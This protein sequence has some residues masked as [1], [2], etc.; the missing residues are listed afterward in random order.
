MD[1]VKMSVPHRVRWRNLSLHAALILAAGCLVVFLVAPLYVMLRQSAFRMD[2]SFAGFDN[3]IAYLSNPRALLSI[4]HSFFVAA[5][6]TLITISL[7]FAYAYC[8]ARTRMRGKSLFRGMAMVP[9]LT[10]SLLFAMSLVQLFGNK[11]LLKPLLF[12][13]SI[14]G[15]IGII[16][17]MVFAHIPH[18]F[19]IL[20]TALSIADARLYEAANCLGASRRRIF[21]TVTLPGIKYG[22]LSAC[23]V[24]FTLCITEFGIPQVIGGQYDVLATDIYKQVIGQQNFQ[25]GSVVSVVLLVPAVIAFILDQ[26]ARRRQVSMLT[27]QIVAYQPR[28]APL[29]DGIAFLFCSLMALAILGIVAVSVGSSFIR[30]WPYDLSLTLK[31]YRF[32]LSAGGGWNAYLNSVKMATLTAVFGTAAIFAGAYLN[33]KSAALPAV[34]RLYQILAMVPMAVPG[35][36]LGLSYIFFFNNPGNPLHFL[37]GTMAIL[38]LSTTVH[39]MTVSHL[40]AVTALS[41]LDPEFESVSDSLRA[42]R[43]RTFFR[44]TLPIC[45]PTILDIAVYYFLGAMT[46]VSAVIFLYSVNT[47]LAAV[48]VLNMNDAGEFA[49]AA[50]MASAIIATCL[51]V[52]VLQFLATRSVRRRAQVWRQRSSEQD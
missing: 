27:S 11:G 24:S 19:L 3:Y 9:L 26:L 49:S 10:P 32:D 5:V 43:Y 23:I 15:P 52:R 4:R 22:L 29:R 35:L 1:S 13:H 2:G 39:Y 8:L 31:H 6:S 25:M 30:F 36:V 45:L 20:S 51:A 17:G 44:I 14:Y 34:R 33:E 7:V 16:A 47:N 50:A 37:Y 40:T 48:A 28:R 42:P 21:F 46:T 18:T 38:V 41:Q 12:G